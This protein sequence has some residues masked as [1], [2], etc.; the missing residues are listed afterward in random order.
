MCSTS[1]KGS[2]YGL[3]RS[4]QLPRNHRLNM[5]RGSPVCNILSSAV[6]R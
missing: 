6:I 1:R 5:R 3:G 4:G 2:N